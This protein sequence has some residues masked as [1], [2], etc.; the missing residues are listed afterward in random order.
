MLT[1]IIYRSHIC[2]DVP[3]KALEAMVAAANRKNRQSNVTG[4]LLFNGTHFFQLL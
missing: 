3:V 1:T 4:I 2:E